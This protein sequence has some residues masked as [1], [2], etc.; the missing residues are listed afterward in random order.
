MRLLFPERGQFIIFGVYAIGFLVICVRMELYK[1][2][3]VKVGVLNIEMC[4]IIRF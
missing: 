1:V 4:G 3:M 2:L